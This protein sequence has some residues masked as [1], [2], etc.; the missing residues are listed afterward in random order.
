MRKALALVLL[1][2]V[3][4][5][6]GGSSTSQASP[7]ASPPAS[8][9]LAL[10]TIPPTDVPNTNPPMDP[11]LAAAFSPEAEA[12]AT[13]LKPVDPHGFTPSELQFGRPPR[14][15]PSVTYQPNVLVMER[16]DTAIRSM[17]SNGMVW[18]FDANAPQV[19]QITQ[20][21][22]IFATE[23]CVGRVGAVKRDGDDVA[24]VLEPVQITDVIQQGH[25][26]Y[27]QPLDLTN[28]VAAPAPDLPVEFRQD[29]IASPSAAPGT[30]PSASGAGSAS[31]ATT[32]AIIRHF[33]LA[34]I[35]YAAVSPSGKWTPFRV[36]TYDARGRV[37]QRFLQR[38]VERVAQAGLGSGPMPSGIPAPPPGIGEPPP[39]QVEINGM[40][41][42]PCM[43]SCGGL[44]IRLKY[45]RN[46]VNV[47]AD[48]VFWLRRPNVQFNVDISLSGIRTA[49]IW[50]NGAAG[51]TTSFTATANQ[52]F[53][54]NIHV[55]QPI[56]L[57]V[58]LPLSFAAPIGVHLIQDLALSSGFSARTSLLTAGITFQACCQFA[59]GYIKGNWKA[60]YPQIS[61]T[62][63]EA[64][65]S[66]VSVGINSLVY[67]M[68]QE[69]LVGLGFAGFST[70]P[71]IALSESMSAL[72]QSSTTWVDCRQATLSMQLDAGVGYTLPSVLV[73]VVNVFLSLANAQPIS[74]HGSLLKMPPAK[75]LNYI[76]SLPKGCAGS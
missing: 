13:M 41:A 67:G 63:P 27:N 34:A 50:I 74:D 7:A 9:A 43:S 6:H 8:G 25:F 65:V 61:V 75:V 26:A 33:R 64:N 72:K 5:C 32:G 56:P 31:P 71:Y 39:Q 36:A 70:G 40:D 22:V 73:K 10:P 52:A 17:D 20:G 46:G 68:S 24:V 47:I 37:T 42:S 66:G 4:A 57:D 14:L 2:A 54:G 29:T 16:G 30:S 3:A 69:L 53:A 1:L 51:F 62:T 35:T 58:T 23:R 59:V 60:D 11:D 49:A 76:G 19:D 44:G 45:S 28:V 38:T 18:H 55:I 21:K 48:S 15:D 12:G